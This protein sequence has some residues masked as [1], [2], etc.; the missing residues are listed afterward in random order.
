MSV[1][2][3]RDWILAAQWPLPK[4]I[5]AGDHY[6]ECA[7]YAAKLIYEWVTADLP[8]RGPLPADTI[9]DWDNDPDHGAEGR[10]A[11]HIVQVG[12]YDLMKQDNIG[13]DELGLTGFMWGWAVNAVR[14]C[15][16]LPPVPNPA[17]ITLKD[18]V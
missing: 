5:E 4:N 18:P 2:Q 6:N 10:K 11:E 7:R 3:M 17:I 13:I 15:L 12:W 14:R 1:E 8:N 9:Y 16:E